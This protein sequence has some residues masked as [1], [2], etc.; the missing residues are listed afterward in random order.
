MKK[1]DHI[2]GAVRINRHNFG[3]FIAQSGGETITFL[4]LSDH[5][6]GVANHNSGAD[7]KYKHMKNNILN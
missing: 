3:V 6:F 1:Q 5:N 7:E 2:V 4:G